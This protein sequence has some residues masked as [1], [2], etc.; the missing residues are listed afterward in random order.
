MV[1]QKELFGE[2]KH[3]EFKADIPKKRER[4]LKDVIAFSNT[5]GGKVI[6]GVEDE[7]REVVG[8]GDRNPFK[9][10]DAIANMVSDS[11]TPE[12]NMEITPKTIDGVLFDLGGKGKIDLYP[13]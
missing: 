10:A 5:A 2:G 9:L 1:V 11:C 8:L 12:I 6:L 13:R 7:T 4:F 3:V